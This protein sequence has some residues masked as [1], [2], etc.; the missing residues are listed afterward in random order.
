MLWMEM[1]QASMHAQQ[2]A[3]NPVLRSGLAEGCSHLEWHLY[4]GLG[5]RVP[6]RTG[7]SSDPVKVLT[8]VFPVCQT[9][10]L[11]GHPD[12]YRGN[13]HLTRPFI[14]DLISIP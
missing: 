11:C 9:P 13:G 3:C 8:T 7:H 10:G 6:G 5:S 1:P 2:P 12:P 4:P 14:T